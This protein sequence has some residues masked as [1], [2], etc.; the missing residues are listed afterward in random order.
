MTDDVIKSAPTRQLKN[1]KRK[2]SSGKFCDAPTTNNNQQQPIHQQFI[3]R[4]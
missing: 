2:I 1:Q 3:T 4:S